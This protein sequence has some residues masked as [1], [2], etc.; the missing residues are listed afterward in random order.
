MLEL[1]VRRNFPRRAVLVYQ[2]DADDRMLL[3]LDGR[4]K[5]TRFTDSGQDVLLGIRDP[6]D[7]LGELAF[8][9]G[10]PRTATIST[11]EAVHALVIPAAALRDYLESVPRVAVVLLRVTAARVRETTLNSVQFAASDTMARLAMRILELA[12]RYGTT[13]DS[14]LAV[15]LPLTQEELTA[16]TGASRAGVSQALRSMRELGW[17]ET[18]RRRLVVRDAEALRARAR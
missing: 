14:D 13:Y 10:L 6:G 15:D 2:D 3:L 5:V 16:W 7:L 8:I 11:L 17:I 4:V 18:N 9:D 1:G 12:E